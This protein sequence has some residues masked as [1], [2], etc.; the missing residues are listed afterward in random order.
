MRQPSEQLQGSSL[1]G[2]F[3][4]D[5]QWELDAFAT[6]IGV[7][8]NPGICGG[9]SDGKQQTT[10]HHKVSH[11]AARRDAALFS[12]LGNRFATHCEVSR[13]VREADQPERNRRDS[14]TANHHGG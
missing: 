4:D 2:R 9:G 7:P 11:P 3:G 14:C 12:V 13:K 5:K 1:R 8:W 10:I 6:F